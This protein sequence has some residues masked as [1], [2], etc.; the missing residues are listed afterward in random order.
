VLSLE[1]LAGVAYGALQAPPP[2]DRTVALTDLPSLRQVAAIGVAAAPPAVAV[3][4]VVPVQGP[5]VPRW[6]V[7]GPVVPAWAVVEP[8]AEPTAVTPPPAVV[9]T[10]R[11]P[12]APLT[13]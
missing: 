7:L 3:P 11:N 13:R 2:Q 1:L 12:F 6:V 9:R 4:A 8:A 5:T 10:G